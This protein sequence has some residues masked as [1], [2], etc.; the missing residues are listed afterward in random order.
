M[1]EYGVILF[2]SSSAAMR[3]EAVLL[4]ANLNIKLIPTPRQFSSDCGIAVRFEWKHVD[5]VRLM[6]EK[7]HTDYSEVR[8]L[9]RK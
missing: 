5:Q 8:Q 1:S 3:A 6:L 9:V 4:R 7:A 2:H